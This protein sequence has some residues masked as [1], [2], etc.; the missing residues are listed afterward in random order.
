MACPARELFLGTGKLKFHRAGQ[1]QAIS[2]AALSAAS[3]AGRSRSEVIG[4][5]ERLIEQ[6]LQWS[7]AAE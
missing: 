1:H 4:V 6:G 7:S 2:G 3:T 5:E